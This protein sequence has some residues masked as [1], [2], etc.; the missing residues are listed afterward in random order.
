ML[1]RKRRGWLF[2]RERNASADYWWWIWHQQRLTNNK[3]NYNRMVNRYRRKP[4]KAQSTKSGKLVED[5]AALSR[6]SALINVG[7]NFKKWRIKTRISRDHRI[8]KCLLFWCSVD[9]YR[10]MGFAGFDKQKPEQIITTTVFGSGGTDSRC[11]GHYNSAVSSL[12]VLKPDG[13]SC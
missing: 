3:L 5:K 8:S 10:Y 2:I 6:V 13:Y 4:W 7:Y 1:R 12:P 9:R 11:C